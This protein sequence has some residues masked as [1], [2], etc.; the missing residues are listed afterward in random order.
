MKYL[1]FFMANI[2]G[3]H[4]HRQFSMKESQ[5]ADLQDGK[6]LGDNVDSEINHSQLISRY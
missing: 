6:K 2:S 3:K 5:H 4:T 1:N